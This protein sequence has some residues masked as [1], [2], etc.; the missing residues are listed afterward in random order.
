MRFFKTIQAKLLIFSFVIFLVPSLIIG[1]VSY[2]QA[3]NGLEEIGETVIKNSVETSLQLIH[4]AEISV[5]SGKL[6]LEDAQE[7][8]KMALIGGKETD[9][10]RPISH[11]ADL[12]ENGYIYIIDHEG[13][14]L[15]HPTREGE[16]L[17]DSQDSSGLYYIREVKEKA[18][19]GGGF[20]YYEFELPGQT[21]EA[22]KLIYS[23]LDE[24][25]GWIVASGT[26]VKDFNEPAKVLLNVIGLT[27]LVTAIICGVLSILFSRHLAVP[28]TKLANRVR[29]VAKGNLIVDLDKTERYDEIGILNRGF[30]EMVGQL[31][32]LIS[33][34]EHTIG[35]I[36]HTS[37]NLT[38]V[39]EETTAFGEDIVKSATA[40]AEGASQQAIDAEQTNQITMGFAQEIDQLQHKNKSMLDSSQQMRQSNEEGLTNL[41][42]LKERSNESY[43]LIREMK[44]VLDSLIIKVREIEGILGTIN[45]ISDQ[46]NLLALNASIEAARA[47]EHGKGFAVVADEVRKL[48]DQT[49]QATV[50]VRNTLRGIELETNVVTTEMEKTYDIVQGQQ[51]SVNMTE[52]S[53]VE[54]ENAVEQIIRVI[55][56]VSTSV[57]HLNTSKNTMLTSIERIAKISETNAGMTEEVTASVDE[58]Q[59]AIQMVT[60]S[61]NDL[62]NELQGLQES[63]SKF[64]IK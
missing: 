10:K 20:T 22:P 33:D 19:A 35:E 9:G 52:K 46:T 30:N 50:L 14:L 4:Q 25:W 17:W 41:V 12:G 31:K 34:V 5:Q 57:V 38:A 23:K 45:D 40:V 3:K 2:I 48:A 6:T 29:Q 28:V 54:I 8:V 53:F 16:S 36:Q 7:Q 64:K 21:V 24:N 61:A 51:Q 58:Q 13:V 63:I 49:S 43:E 32:V 62:T 11:P 15:G 27:L 26:Y 55:E 39:A 18:L 56:D 60:E 1:T 47:G 59:N 37:T 42:T 44:G